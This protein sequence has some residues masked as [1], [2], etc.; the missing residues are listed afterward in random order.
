MAL[1]CILVCVT[2][3][4][5]ASLAP[6]TTMLS[7]LTHSGSATS[8]LTI[9]VTP[10]MATQPTTVTTSTV[11]VTPST[12]SV[13]SASTTAPQPDQPDQP[14]VFETIPTE[15]ISGNGMVVQSP[16]M[17]TLLYPSNI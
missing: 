6:W 14:E 10:I 1:L 15:C 2:Y 8:H 9:S 7:Y 11:I 4:L 16:A 3:Q 12:A 13:L 5:A 17:L